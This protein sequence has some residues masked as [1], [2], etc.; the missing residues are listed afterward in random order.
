M[1]KQATLSDVIYNAAEQAFE[2]VV[3]IQSV[4]GPLRYAASYHAPMTTEFEQAASGLIDRAERMHKLNR[5]MRAVSARR[6]ALPPM[7]RPRAGRT[8]APRWLDRFLSHAHA[9]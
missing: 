3:T 2:A 9:A 5:G 4:R 8:R 6:L 7:A 1:T